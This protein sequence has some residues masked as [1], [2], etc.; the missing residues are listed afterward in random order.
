LSEVAEREEAPDAYARWVAMWREGVRASGSVVGVV[1]LETAR[2]LELSSG[3]AELLGTTPEQGVGLDYLSVTERPEVAAETFRMA[4]EGIF[5]GIQGKRR[6]RRPDGSAVEMQARGWAIR[7][8]SGPDLAVWGASDPCPQGADV[9][10]SALPSSMMPQLPQARVSLD[11]RWRIVQS[12]ANADF[13]FG[14][15]SAALIGRSFIE[16]THAHD[17]AGLLFSLARATS[18]TSVS[19]RIRLRQPDGGWRPVYVEPAL[20]DG[21]RGPLPFALVVTAAAELADPD[22]NRHASQLAEHLRR[23]AAHIEAAGALAPLIETADDIGFPALDEL[24]A[25][26][27]EIASRLVQGQRVA[28]IAAELFLSQSTVR[29]HLSAIFQK[30]GVHSQ[31]EFLALWR[32]VTRS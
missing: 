1:E 26:Q 27:W 23:I 28:A 6:F 7:S 3:A 11:D 21:D 19:V 12:G 31:S 15:S 20:L 17:V 32:A 5:D 25:R 30:F 2:F 4:R 29:N 13:V 18:D 16:L 8:L 10:A 14:L 9:I 22:L 24:S